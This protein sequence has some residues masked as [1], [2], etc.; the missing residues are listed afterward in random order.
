LCAAD[1][2]G[3]RGGTRKYAK[4]GMQDTWLFLAYLALKNTRKK[5]KKVLT[6]A[7]SCVIIY[8]VAGQ[9]AGEQNQQVKG[10]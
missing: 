3:V 8:H 2:P 6:N 7:K 4:N 9:N 10:I 5:S 1:T